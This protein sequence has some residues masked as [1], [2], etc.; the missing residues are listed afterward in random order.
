MKSDVIRITS[1]GAGIAEALKQTEAVAVFKSLS[2]NDS[3]HL[4]LIAEEMTGMFKQLTGELTGEFWIE[5]EGSDFHFHLRTSTEM[6]SEKREKLLAATTSG[7]NTTKGF[8]SKVK[9]AFEA[10]LCSMERGYSD[11]VD[12]GIVE[13]GLNTGFSVWTL[14]Q[15]KTNVAKEESDELESSVVANLADEIKVSINGSNVEM[16]IEKSV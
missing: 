11:S 4:L 3:I 5:A 6:N 9:S 7:K 13:T 15:Y 10:A 16:I 2:K 12:L 8:M 14:S 1:D